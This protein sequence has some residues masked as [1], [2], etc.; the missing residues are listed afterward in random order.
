MRK[1][2]TNIKMDLKDVG[3]MTWTGLIW[4]RIGTCGGCCERGEKFS[5]SMKWREF[6]DYVR[7]C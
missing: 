2:T 7:S 1:Q 5:G 4:L 3:L 6:L